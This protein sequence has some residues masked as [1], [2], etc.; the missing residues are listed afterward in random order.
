MSV[1][2][3]CHDLPKKL[4][5]GSRSVPEGPTHQSE[6]GSTFTRLMSS[7][8]K[9]CGLTA[10]TR[11]SQPVNQRLSQGPATTQTKGH[12]KGQPTSKPKVITRASNQPNQRPSQ[13]PANQ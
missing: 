11:A 3:I 5:A 9:P 12:H 8:I 1:L 13:E 6:P 2:C 10:I 4:S 7:L